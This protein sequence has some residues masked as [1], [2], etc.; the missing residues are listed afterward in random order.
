M[1][2]D[3]LV[4]KATQISDI[5]N[6]TTLRDSLEVLSTQFVFTFLQIYKHV[7]R[8]D[9]VEKEMRN[10]FK[11]ISETLYKLINDH[12]EIFEE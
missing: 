8:I 1:D 11:S 2:K 4:E 6:G 10:N 3:V 7:H 9:L 5:L 12:E